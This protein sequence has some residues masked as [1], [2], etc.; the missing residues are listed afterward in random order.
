[1]L[2]RLFGALPFIGAKGADVTRSA[3]GRLAGE[4]VPMPTFALHR[5]VR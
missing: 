2:W 1:M 3:A 4:F 5:D